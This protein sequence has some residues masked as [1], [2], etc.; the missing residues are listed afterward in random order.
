MPNAPASTA[1]AGGLLS[2]PPVRRAASR[3]SI[4]EI[5]EA[6]VSVTASEPPPAEPRIPW[7]GS[8]MGPV[9]LRRTAALAL[10]LSLAVTGCSR[11]RTGA[12]ASSGPPALNATS[13]PLLPTRVSAL[14]SFDFDSYRSLLRQLRGTPVVVNI[15]ASWCGPCREEA[16]HLAEAARTY[17]SRVQFLGVDILDQRAAAAS[18]IARYGWPYP[19]VFDPSGDIRD[20]LGFLGQPVTAFYSPS[21]RLV[22]SWSGPL[23]PSVLGERIAS[24]LGPSA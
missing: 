17:G 9:T 6:S 7:V 22:S 1:A 5:G 2:C 10:A 11:A 23:T 13:V 21:G 3:R 19:S 15:W 14:P 24:I 18:F 12:E 8:T 16:P 20:G 4:A